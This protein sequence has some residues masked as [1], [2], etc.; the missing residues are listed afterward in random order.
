M[1]YTGFC[2]LRLRDRVQLLSMPPGCTGSDTGEVLKIGAQLIHVLM[3]RRGNGPTIR[4][5]EPWAVRKIL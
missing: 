1:R 4:Q 5:V 3:D 2:G